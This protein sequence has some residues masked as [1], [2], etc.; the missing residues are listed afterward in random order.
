[1]IT[2]SGSA[3]GLHVSTPNYAEL[4]SS[5]SA[6]RRIQEDVG[7]AD[8]HPGAADGPGQVCGGPLEVLG[9]LLDTPADG[10]ERA[11]ATAGANWVDGDVPG[12]VG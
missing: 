9:E 7:G 3:C 2:A 1:L 10:D 4:P 8:G 11:Q 12:A 6:A 5:C